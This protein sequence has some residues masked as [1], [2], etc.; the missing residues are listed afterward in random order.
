[1]FANSAYVVFGT[2]RVNLNKPNGLSYSCQLA[3]FILIFRASGVIF[4]FYFIFSSPEP[5][6]H[7]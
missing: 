5:K 2:L 3:E 1:M 6:A 4:H 7:R